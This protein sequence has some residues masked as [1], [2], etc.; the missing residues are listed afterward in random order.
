[1]LECCR[2]G[3]NLAN[4][5][6]RPQHCPVSHQTNPPLRSRLTFTSLPIARA[7]AGERQAPIKTQARS[8]TILPNFVGLKFQV[9][10]G[11]KYDDITITEDMVG[12]K[13][14]EFAPYVCMDSEDSRTGD[15]WLTELNRTRKNFS[16]KQTKNK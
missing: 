6:Y 1:M 3:E 10:N 7:K 2:N 13:L 9:H 15:M 11:K 14:G 5:T 12:H 16:Y 4:D 8:A